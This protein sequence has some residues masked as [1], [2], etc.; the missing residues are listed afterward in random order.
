MKLIILQNHSVIKAL[1]VKQHTN[2]FGYI[3][4]RKRWRL[5]TKC[6]H[7]QTHNL[8]IYCVPILTLRCCSWCI[9]PVLKAAVGTAY[10]NGIGFRLHLWRLFH[11]FHTNTIQ[12]CDQKIKVLSRNEWSQGD[13]ISK[14]LLSSTLY[15]FSPQLD[16]NTKVTS[17]DLH[18]II[19]CNIKNKP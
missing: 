7:V 13:K 6:C 12:M 11:G 9:E 14:P 10:L 16:H 8:H 4:L 18:L 1:M 5:C 3:T 17:Q 15:P 19:C 2:I